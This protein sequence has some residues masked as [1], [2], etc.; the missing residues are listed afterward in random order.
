MT[1]PGVDP[2]LYHAPG[3]TARIHLGQAGK[4]AQSKIAMHE[5]PE[6]KAGC[7]QGESGRPG[8][9]IA[10]EAPGK[11]PMPRQEKPRTRSDP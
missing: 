2:G 4:A 5:A 11:E 3:I 6:R 9:G 7:Y 10:V 1:N 8:E